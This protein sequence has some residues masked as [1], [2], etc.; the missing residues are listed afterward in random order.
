MG[1]GGSEC[2]WSY[3]CLIKATTTELC[4]V[5]VSKRALLAAALIPLVLVSG[6]VAIGTGNKAPSHSVADVRRIFES[7]PYRMSFREP[8]NRSGVIEG[9]AW[10]H[11]NTSMRW[12]AAVGSAKLPP[13]AFSRRWDPGGGSEFVFSDNDLELAPSNRREWHELVRMSVAMN[14]AMCRLFTG[15]PCE[16]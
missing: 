10:T 12:M 7:L 8:L 3:R 15:G 4:G 13:I 6:A 14:E 1:R 9:Q 16:I 2:A 5:S 11:R